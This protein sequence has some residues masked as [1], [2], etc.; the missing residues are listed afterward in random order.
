MLD[1]MTVVGLPSPPLEL[2]GKVSRYV[3]TAKEQDVAAGSSFSA[4]LQG[5]NTDWR[6]PQDGCSLTEVEGRYEYK[7]PGSIQ[8]VFVSVTDTDAEPNLVVKIASS[9]GKGKGILSVSNPGPQ[10]SSGGVRIAIGE[11]EYNMAAFP[12]EGVKKVQ[13]DTEKGELV[14]SQAG[15]QERH[16]V[17]RNGV[18]MENP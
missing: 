1:R 12:A 8:D 5:V 16:Y 14:L 3:H 13:V 2:Q 4:S 17:L 9:Q 15:G 11:I 18:L 7:L 6:V 10:E